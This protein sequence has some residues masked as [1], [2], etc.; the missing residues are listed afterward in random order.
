MADEK[1]GILDVTCDVAI[2]IEGEEKP[3]VAAEW[4]FRIVLAQ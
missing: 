4:I 2:E 3:A 1:P